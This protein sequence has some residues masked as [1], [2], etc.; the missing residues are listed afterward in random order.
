MLLASTELYDPVINSFAAAAD[1]ATW[2]Y[3]RALGLR[4]D[5]TVQEHSGTWRDAGPLATSVG[6]SQVVNDAPATIGAARVRGALWRQGTLEPPRLAWIQ[7][8]PDA[9]HRGLTIIPRTRR[10]TSPGRC[11]TQRPPT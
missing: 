4:S 1:T 2:T 10:D 3:E 11:R 9:E 8:I 6:T 5:R 7:K